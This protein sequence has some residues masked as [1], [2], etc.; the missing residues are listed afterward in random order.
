[1]S[2]TNTTYTKGLHEIGTGH[3]AYLLPDGSWG[4][5]NAGL[6]TSGSHSM[7]VDTLMTLGLTREMLDTMRSAVPAA[8]SFDT[9]VNSHA[10]PDHVWG[11]QLV[12]NA[13]VIATR[14]AVEEIE[15]FT[16]EGLINMVANAPNMGIAGEFIQRAFGAPF[17][18]SGIELRIPEKTFTGELTVNVGDKVVRLYDV[19]PAH[20]RGD[21]IVHVPDDR[22]AYVADL[23]FVDG[24]P[25]LWAGPI[26]NWIAV[27]DRIVSLDLEVVVPGHGPLT[28]QSGVREFRDYLAYVNQEAH[29]FHAE[30]LSRYEAALALDVSRWEHWS[31]A[32][33]VVIAMYTIYRDIEQDTSPIDR[34]PLWED[35]GR[36]LLEKTGSV[37]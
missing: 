28:D 37:Q 17:D 24:H 1:M 11:N 22:I 4:W 30:G 10:D 13:Q 3:Y 29:R 5:S 34:M 21:L 31:D 6:I 8:A 36:Y 2:T 33:R 16:P 19:G 27:C 23:L 32:E 12:G 35:M 7:L 14:A 26:D 18:F 25:A 15:V 9:L 20:S